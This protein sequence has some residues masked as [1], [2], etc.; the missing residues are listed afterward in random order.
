MMKRYLVV[1]TFATDE[2]D[3]AGL[4]VRKPGDEIDLTEEAY[5][6]LQKLHPGALREMDPKTK[7]DWEPAD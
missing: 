2:S 6:A 1:R 5:Q 7:R 3:D 4:I